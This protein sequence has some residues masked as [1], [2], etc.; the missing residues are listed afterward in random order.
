MHSTNIEWVKNIMVNIPNN[1]LA[2]NKID[3]NEIILI[4]IHLLLNKI[5]RMEWIH[6]G[7]IECN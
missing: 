5:Q 6:Y 3:F 2:K 4:L 7:N 1:I